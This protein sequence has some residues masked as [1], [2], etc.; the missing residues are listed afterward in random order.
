MV[1]SALALPFGWKTP[2]AHDLALLVLIGLM[3]GVA[4]LAITR[5]F[6]LAP[7]A[8]VAP[9]DYTALPYTAAL[10]YFIWGDVPEP[11]FLLGALIVIGS[12]LYILHRETRVARLPLP[13]ASIANEG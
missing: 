1:A 2:D 8:V 7:P 10:G 11:I 9:F 4:Q 12:G 5:A 13:V 3:G 6:R